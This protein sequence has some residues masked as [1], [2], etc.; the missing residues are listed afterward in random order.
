MTFEIDE[1]FKVTFVNE[2][3]SMTFVQETYPDGTTFESFEEATEWA[4]S[5]VE[6]MVNPEV[7]AIPYPARVADK[8][9]NTVES[10][11]ELAERLA[12]EAQLEAPAEEPAPAE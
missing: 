9:T 10:A 5:F 12:F 4:E 3:G 8:Y 1:N 2:D 7:R 6:S 11:E